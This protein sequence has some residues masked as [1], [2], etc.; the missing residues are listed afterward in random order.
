MS[1][2]YKSFPHFKDF[3]GAFND[4]I[5]KLSI[6]LTKLHSITALD[7]KGECLDQ[8]QY[9]KNFL[10]MK[11]AIHICGY[12][13]LPY[14]VTSIVDFCTGHFQESHIVDCLFTIFRNSVEVQMHR[15]ISTVSM[16]L[17]AKFPE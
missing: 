11:V 10:V 7:S 5:W 14:H 2:F 8:W 1:V 13:N 6:K 17:C 12:F 16:Y 3:S 4:T 9:L 15:Q